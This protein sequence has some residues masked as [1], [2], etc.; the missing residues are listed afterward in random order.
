MHKTLSQPQDKTD[1]NGALD[2]IVSLRGL[3]QEL[4]RYIDLRGVFEPGKDNT[5][6]SS[7][8]L[9]KIAG[10]LTDLT[11]AIVTL[12]CTLPAEHL[13]DVIIKLAIAKTLLESPDLDLSS[14]QHGKI[15][16]SAQEDLAS[17]SKGAS[18]TPSGVS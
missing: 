4:R 9:G 17:L 13:D 1:A 3:Q 7:A 11:Q 6:Q 8:V 16:S 10:E 5:H 2:Q 15:L 18:S 12:A 14:P